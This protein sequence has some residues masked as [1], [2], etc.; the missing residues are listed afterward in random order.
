M[1][2]RQHNN[3]RINVLLQHVSTQDSHRQADCLRTINTLYTLQYYTCNF[4]ALGIPYAL[5][6]V[7]RK[8]LVHY[9]SAFLPK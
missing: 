4:F 1:S 6:C 7:S 3:I 8:N 9:C 2:F 5:H